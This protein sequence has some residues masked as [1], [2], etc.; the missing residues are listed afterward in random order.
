MLL[1]VWQMI[2]YKKFLII[3]RMINENMLSLFSPIT[4]QVSS[5][6]N[7]E[8]EWGIIVFALTFMGYTWIYYNQD[9]MTWKV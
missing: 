9:S 7:T 3:I 4:L 8:I 5:S 6:F 1:T 2:L